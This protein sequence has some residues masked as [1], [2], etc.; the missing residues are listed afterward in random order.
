MGRIIESPSEKVG[1][2]EKEG[3][4]NGGARE[5]GNA[6]A[7]IA[8]QK[9]S[10]A[11]EGEER[12]KVV[13]VLAVPAPRNDDVG[14]EDGD[15]KGADYIHERGE[16]ED[17]VEDDDGGGEEGENENGETEVWPIETGE[18]DELGDEENDDAE[19]KS[20]VDGEDEV[21]DGGDEEGELEQMVFRKHPEGIEGA[22]EDAGEFD[23]SE[24]GAAGGK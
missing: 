6:G 2:F 7:D 19:D 20:V 24:A 22:E 4:E 15:V 23:E 11:G 16:V 3:G 14:G 8:G 9:E 10:E 1:G 17:H 12:E 5:V 21:G 13:A 18:M